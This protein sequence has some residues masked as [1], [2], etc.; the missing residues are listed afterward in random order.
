MADPIVQ[1]RID[2]LATYIQL[3]PGD[4]NYKDPSFI[5]FPVRHPDMQET[6]KLPIN[7]VPSEGSESTRKIGKIIDLASRNVRVDFSPTL[8]TDTIIGEVKAYRYELYGARYIK[9]DVAFMYP[10]TNWVNRTGFDI[11]IDNDEP[12]PGIIIEYD[13]TPVI[14][15][16]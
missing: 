5:F 8:L 15:E 16:P 12:L 6:M 3:E 1:K 7:T 11:V 14:S 10:S 9:Q 2:E 13:F 4:P